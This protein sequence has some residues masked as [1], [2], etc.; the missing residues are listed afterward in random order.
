M[1]TNL[2]FYHRG[3]IGSVILVH[4]VTNAT[5]LLLVVL[6][7]GVLTDAEGQPLSLWFFV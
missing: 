1:L 5:I 7:S 2:W 3:H 6:G 4:A